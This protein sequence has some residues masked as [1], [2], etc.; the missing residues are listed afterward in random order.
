MSNDRWMD[1]DM[2]YTNNGILA[3]KKEWNI[4]ICSN[5]DGPK[6]CHIKWS[7]TDKDKYQVSLSGILKKKDTN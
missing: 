6:D 1:K 4:A 7:Q 5:M 3:I 2:A